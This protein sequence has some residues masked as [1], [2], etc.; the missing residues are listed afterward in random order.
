MESSKWP[1]GSLGFFRSARFY[2]KGYKLD[3]SELWPHSLVKKLTRCG[4]GCR[5]PQLLL[6]VFPLSMC[7]GPSRTMSS[8]R[9]KSWS[10]VP[11]EARPVFG[12]VASKSNKPWRNNKASFLLAETGHSCMS[13]KSVTPQLLLEELAKSPCLYHVCNDSGGGSIA[14]QGNRGGWRQMT[15]TALHLKDNSYFT[16]ML[17]VRWSL[18]F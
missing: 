13:S 1:Y 10:Q 12:K 11:Q 2:R 14:E 4:H 3:T 5:S 7:R 18:P 17:F 8:A 16:F 15:K 6:P 9:L